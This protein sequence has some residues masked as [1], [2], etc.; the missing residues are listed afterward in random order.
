MTAADYDHQNDDNQL[1]DTQQKHGCSL[2]RH[3]MTH[4]WRYHMTSSTTSSN[5]ESFISTAPCQWPFYLDTSTRR[6]TITSMASG[7][8]IYFFTYPKRISDIQKH[9]FD[10]R[11]ITLVLNYF[12]CPKY[13]FQISIITISDTWKNK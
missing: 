3:W 7:I 8:N 5:A 6:P 1:L 10:I 9:Y 12:G 11:N 2:R 13:L 4:S